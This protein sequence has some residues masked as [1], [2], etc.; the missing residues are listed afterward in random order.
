MQRLYE[1]L[2]DDTS[3]F[4]ATGRLYKKVL[5]IAQLKLADKYKVYGTRH[6]ING[7]EPK[8]FVKTQC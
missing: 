6:G 2:I 7:S 1:K 3:Q 5:V 8:G 4:L